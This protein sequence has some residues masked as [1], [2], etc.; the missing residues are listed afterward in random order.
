MRDPSRAPSRDRSRDPGRQPRASARWGFALAAAAL[1]GGLVAEPARAGTIDFE[2]G[3]PGSDAATLPA[4]GVSITGALILDEALVETL[5]GY[6]ASGTWNTTP[7]GTNGAINTL[8]AEIAL[9]F[10]IPVSFVGVDVLSLP[11]DAGDPGDVLL[12]AFDGDDPVA[13]VR[14]DPA[15]AAIGDS[16]QPEGRLTIFAES[17]SRAVLCVPDPDAPFAC[18]APGRV[19]SFWIDGID[20]TPVPEPGTA[21]LLGLALAV[22]ARRRTL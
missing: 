22:I 20:F 17:I 11:D 5:L 8:A 3:A 6:P 18:L 9:A 15:T 1:L 19:T 14:L 21:A 4:S 16:G 10:D 2:D 7:G 12:V 13:S